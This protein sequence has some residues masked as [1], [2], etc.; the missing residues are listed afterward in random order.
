MPAAGD[1][2]YG[3]PLAGTGLPECQQLLTTDS[4]YSQ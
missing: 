2:L 4:T 3:Q 1:G